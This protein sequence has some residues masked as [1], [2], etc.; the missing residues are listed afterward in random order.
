MGRPMADESKTS[1]FRKESL[2][3][4]SSPEQLDQ[5]MQVVNAKSWI[6]L[7]AL[8]SLVFLALGWSVVGRIPITAIGRGILVYPTGSETDSANELVNIS[9]FEPRTAE[10]I[11]PGMPIIIVPDTGSQR[12]GGI[13]GRVTSV[14]GSS[15]TTVDAARQAM[16]SNPLSTESIEVMA[17]LQRDA[18]TGAYQGSAGN[19]ARLVPGT[20]TTAR[21]T[22]AERAPITF[23]F[24]FLEA[25]Q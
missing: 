11:Q 6:P 3:R 20:T 19:V 4:L 7:A 12:M 13:V 9:F 14:K 23:V 5:L 8:G 16:A 10:R 18:G 25:E 24:P 15:I 2:E 1:I 17:E 21:I 22:L